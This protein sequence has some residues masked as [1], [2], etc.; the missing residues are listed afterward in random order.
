MQHFVTCR[1]QYLIDPVHSASAQANTVLVTGVPT[2]FLNEAALTKLFSHVP[3]GVRKIWL[4]RDLKE[5]PELYDRRLKACNMLESA[6]TS[7]LNMATKKH[8]KIL[9]KQAK[10]AKKGKVTGGGNG[11]SDGLTRPAQPP[12]RA[13]SGMVRLIQACSLLRRSGR[14]YSYVAS[15][16]PRYVIRCEYQH[17]ESIIRTAHCH[18][19]GHNSNSLG[20]KR[21]LHT[22][23]SRRRG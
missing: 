7:L 15:S 14:V 22:S 9:K 19:N 3:G 11:S 23:T 4:N 10:Q 21:K 20:T 16:L 8:N 5:L 2:Q 13:I 18:V 17:V 1:Q 6:E 12:R